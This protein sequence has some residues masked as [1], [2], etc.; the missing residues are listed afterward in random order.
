MVLLQDTLSGVCI[1]VVYGVLT[2]CKHSKVKT[3]D[4]IGLFGRTA[5][6]IQ[7]EKFLVLSFQS[8]MHTAQ[9]KKIKTH[10]LE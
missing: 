1:E 7:C 4:L 5:K 3:I 9:Y 6:H 10:N 2:L 8:T